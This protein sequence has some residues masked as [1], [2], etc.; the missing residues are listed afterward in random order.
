VNVHRAVT[1]ILTLLAAALI[2][3]PAVSSACPW[4]SPSTQAHTTV[5]TA[6]GPKAERV[7]YVPA[8]PDLTGY[9]NTTTTAPP[10]PPPPPPAPAPKAP[11][12]KPAPPPPPPPPPPAQV[13][14]GG[15]GHAEVNQF[16]AANGLGA[17]AWDGTLYTKAVGWAQHLAAAGS[18]SHSASGAGVPAGWRTV[19]ENVGYGPSVSSVLTAFQNSA[20]HRA[21]LLN[22]AFTRVAVGI[23]EANGTYWVTEE[24]Y[25]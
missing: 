1:A 7:S 24:F 9:P 18:L 22:P 19:G 20:P 21:N 4:C 14:S 25:G 16:R 13:V 3:S 5:T 23:V 12:V 8:V 15:T 6:P 2:G 11:V 17:L 10:P